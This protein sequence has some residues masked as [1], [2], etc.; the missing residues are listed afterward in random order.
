MSHIF[1]SYQ[2]ED[3]DFAAVL[4]MELEKAGF[5]TWLDKQRL[6]AGS[7]WSEEIDQGV[8]AAAALVLVLSP[9]SRASEYVTYEWSCAI[10]AGVR[11]VPLLRRDTEIH[12]RLRRLQYLDFRGNVRPW[13][14]LF[15]EL[16]SIALESQTYWR[17]PRDTPPHI[18]RALSDLN[19]GNIDDRTGAMSAITSSDHHVVVPALLH[20]LLSPFRD[21]RTSALGSL[22][23]R[24]HPSVKTEAALSVLLEY[25]QDQAIPRP[26]R[27]TTAGQMIIKKVGIDYLGTKLIS[28]E[29]RSLSLIKA[30]GFIGGME[31]ISIL[32]KLTKNPNPDIV[33]VAIEELKRLNESGERGS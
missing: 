6:R 17:P 32:L 1:I 5:D 30:L 8:R 20:A 2:Q 26:S 23:M 7:D 29:V 15:G 3:A 31:V 27:Y 10:G 33:R 16:Q 13:S 14:N 18:Q 11:V 12:P 21:V 24:D 4:M 19:S 28:G 22:A 25:L 9:A